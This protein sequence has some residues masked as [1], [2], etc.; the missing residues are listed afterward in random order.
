PA[1]R[2]ALGPRGGSSFTCLASAS[3]RLVSPAIADT[4]TTTPLPRACVARQRRATSRIRSTEPTD[5]PPYFCTTS[6]GM[7]P[8]AS[9]ISRR[10]AMLARHGRDPVTTACVVLVTFPAEEPAVSCARMLVD[11]HLAACVNVV[12]RVRSIYRWQGAVADE[13]EVL[14]IIK[15]TRERFE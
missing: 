9:P 4:I 11:E 13:S 6:G 2:S 3:R 12:G 7:E 8:R 10:K 5:V 15:T 14:C 1:P